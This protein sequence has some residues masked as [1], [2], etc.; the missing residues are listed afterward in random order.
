[1]EEFGLAMH[2]A[3]QPGCVSTVPGG[4]RPLSLFEQKYRDSGHRLWRFTAAI[5][6]YPGEKSQ[7][8]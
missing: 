8:P 2:L 4:E 6:Q 1:V 7:F 3:G 5:A